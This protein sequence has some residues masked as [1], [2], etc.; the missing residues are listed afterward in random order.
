MVFKYWRPSFLESRNSVIHFHDVVYISDMLWTLDSWLKRTSVTSCDQCWWQHWGNWIVEEFSSTIQLPVLVCP[1][2]KGQGIRI[3]DGSE[4]QSDFGS[5]CQSSVILRLVGNGKT[6][7]AYFGWNGRPFFVLLCDVETAAFML[8]PWAAFM[9][10]ALWLAS[11]WDHFPCVESF[12]CKPQANHFLKKWSVRG[13]QQINL[14]S[15]IFR[16]WIDHWLC[17]LTDNDNFL[18]FKNFSLS[19]SLCC[20][21]WPAIWAKLSKWSWDSDSEKG[22]SVFKTSLV[23][24]YKAFLWKASNPILALCNLKKMVVGLWHSK[25]NQCFGDKPCSLISFCHLQLQHPYFSQTMTVSGVEKRSPD[26]FTI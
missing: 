20:T 5:H 15:Q 26:E 25:R 17:N 16:L 11:L 3:V 6:K 23:S 7:A 8:L 1:I 10:S 14:C 22:I 9:W 18:R 19:E 24:Q 2:T 4:L 12:S 21:I 13:L